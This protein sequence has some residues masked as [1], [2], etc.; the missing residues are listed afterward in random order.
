M[1]QTKRVS[2]SEWQEMALK[3]DI[4]IIVKKLN[5]HESILFSLC[6]ELVLALGTI[7]LDHLFDTEKAPIWVWILLV[8]LAILPPAIVL[9]IHF[10]KWWRI[11]KAVRIGRLNTKSYIDT[12]D[13]QISY[14]VMLCNSYKNMLYDDSPDTQA[15]KHFLYCEG[16]YFNNKSMHALYTMKPNFQAVFSSD[17]DVVK[18]NGL[19][20]LSRLTTTLELIKKQQEELDNAV[21]DSTD[22]AIINQRNLN[23]KYA[24]ELQDLLKDMQRYYGNVFDFRWD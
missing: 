3:K 7:I 18:K 4:E 11:I 16:S 6:W 5:S 19:I 23:R 8:V 10:I 24:D 22:P 2:F 14:W 20:E 12:F 1:F 9:A 21:A 17:I 13:N 15:E